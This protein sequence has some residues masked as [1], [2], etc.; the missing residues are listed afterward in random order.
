MRKLINVI[1]FIFIFVIPLYVI[2]ITVKYVSM[3]DEYNTFLTKVLQY[4]DTILAVTTELNNAGYIREALA[5]A[6]TAVRVEDINQWWHMNIFDWANDTNQ[7]LS[8][9][10]KYFD[11]WMQTGKLL[12][13]EPEPEQIPG[14]SV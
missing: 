11:Y 14:Q 2:A 6:H 3:T 10:S 5:I 9:P 4:D 8:V 12:F 7:F 1:L 13:P